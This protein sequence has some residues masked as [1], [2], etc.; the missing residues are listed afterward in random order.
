MHALDFY[1][2]LQLREFNFAEAQVHRSRSGGAYVCGE[3]MVCT[4]KNT[5]ECNVVTDLCI[6]FTYVEVCGTE[7]V[8]YSNN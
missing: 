4:V 3:V 2:L 7:Q 1:T 6:G 8:K 5:C